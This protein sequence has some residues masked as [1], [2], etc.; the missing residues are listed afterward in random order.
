MPEPL[1]AAAAQAAR[2]WGIARVA[3]E[4]NVGY[5]GLRR[6]VGA[7]LPERL[8]AGGFVEVTGADLV[9]GPLAGG[10]VIEYARPEGGRLTITVPAGSSVDVL[11]LVTALRGP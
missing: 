7:G 1:W 10:T 3:S 4:L 11:A 5:A 8:D 2:T 9:G 6:R